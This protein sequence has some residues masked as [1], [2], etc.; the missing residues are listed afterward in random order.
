MLRDIKPD[1]VWHRMQILQNPGTALS[2]KLAIHP[3]LMAY[4]EHTHKPFCFDNV[5]KR[6]NHLQIELLALSHSS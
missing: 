3:C 6:T 4:T 2:F 5:S 1:L